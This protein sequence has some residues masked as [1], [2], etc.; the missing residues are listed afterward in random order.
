MHR[1]ITG[2]ILIILMSIGVLI[3]AAQGMTAKDIQ[4]KSIDVTRIDGTEALSTLIIMNEKG[5]KRIRKMAVVTKQFEKGTLEKKLIKFTEPADVNG[6]GFLTYDYDSKSDDKWIYLPALRK[7]R[8][9]ISAENAKSFMGSEFSYADM[10]RPDVEEFTYKF[11]PDEAVNGENC[12]VLEIIPLN[13]ELEDENGFSKK[14][15]YISKKDHLL[16]KSVY[17]D[18]YG[19]KE[20]IMTVK[21]IVEVDKQKHK[22]RLKEIEMENVQNGRTSISRIE[23]IQ[24][25]PNISDEYFTT[26]YLEK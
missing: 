3:S 7:T 5:E 26:R 11:L 1:L 22:Y 21:S 6:T 20:K 15:S 24:F 17:F 2:I 8:R 19:D 16:R 9:I 23:T 14:I 10:S 12:Y 13:S 25:N 18:L 4:Q